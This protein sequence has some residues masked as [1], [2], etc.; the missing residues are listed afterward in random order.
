MKKNEKSI[1]N[2]VLQDAIWQVKVIVDSQHFEIKQLNKYHLDLISNIDSFIAQDFHILD[3]LKFKKKITTTKNNKIGLNDL[4]WIG[5]L[6][7]ILSFDRFLYS[8]VLL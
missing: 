2:V 8:I 4:W 5:E 1:A 3:I 7:S 6:V